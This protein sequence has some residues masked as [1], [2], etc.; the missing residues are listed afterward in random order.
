[1]PAVS[2]PIQCKNCNWTRL[3]SSV[4]RA[5]GLPSTPA[6]SALDSLPHGQSALAGVVTE[7]LLVMARR[8][9]CPSFAALEMFPDGYRARDLP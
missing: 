7:I 9:E 5:M 6:C 4:G 3:P 8:K 1:M 2:G